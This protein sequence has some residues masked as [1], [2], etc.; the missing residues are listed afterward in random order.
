MS[1]NFLLAFAFLFNLKQFAHRNLNVLHHL[2]YK[3]SNNAQRTHT[4]EST[5]CVFKLHD[6]EQDEHLFKIM[7]GCLQYKNS[8]NSVTSKVKQFGA[9]CYLSH[10]LWDSS[11]A[12]AISRGGTQQNGRKFLLGLLP[13]AEET[14]SNQAAMQMLHKVASSFDMGW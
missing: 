3:N 1:L 6:P 5:V 12:D 8:S 9:R 10:R 2:F 13:S 11:Q 4:Y 14:L 7:N